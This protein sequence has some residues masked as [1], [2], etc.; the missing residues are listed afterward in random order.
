MPTVDQVLTQMPEV[1]KKL[2]RIERQIPPLEAARE[3]CRRKAVKE[4]SDAIIAVGS[5]YGFVVQGA[6]DRVVIT[7][8]HCLPQLPS[9]NVGQRAGE[10]LYP[11]LLGPLGGEQ[12]VAAAC[13]FAD[14]ISDIAAL[15]FPNGIEAP[16]EFRQF[17]QLT[18][19][20]TPLSIVEPVLASLV[21]I[22]SPDRD[23]LSYV[24]RSAWGEQ[25]LMIGIDEILVEMSGVPIVSDAGA[26]IGVFCPD[27][28]RGFLGGAHPG[29]VGSLPR[30]LLRIL[31]VPATSPAP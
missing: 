16:E 12:T 14:R 31:S 19:A 5:G 2:E 1:S 24:A 13:Y 26:A 30:R 25:L 7:A 6:Y 15:G 9:S 23:W 3:K 17:L 29:L 11:T 22:P 8:A 28:E 4:W 21:W 18:D 20:A 10:T 27:P